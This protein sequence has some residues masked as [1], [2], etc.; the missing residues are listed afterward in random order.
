MTRRIKVEALARVEGEGALDVTVRDGRVTALHFRIFEPPRFFEALLRGRPYSDAPDITSRI[1]GIC[2]IA[3]Q[4]GA[5][6]AMED[7]FGVV[8]S[9][10]IEA[11]RRLVYCGEWI[12]S[13]VL[14]VAMLHAPDFLGLDDALLMA[15][16]HPEVVETALRLKKLGNRLLEVVGGRAVHP[17]NLK[18]GGFYA[19]PKRAE[20]LALRPELDWAAAAA[21]RLLRTVAAFDPPDLTRDYL[22]VAL[23]HDRDYAITGGRLASSEGLDAPIAA[24]PDLFD[25]H[26]EPNSTALHGRTRDGRAYMV[27]PLARWAING[28]RLLPD[29]RAEAAALGVAPVER[30]PFR[31]IVVRAAE[32]LQVVLEAQR[33]VDAYRPPDPPAVPVEPRAGVGVGATEAP[34]GLCWHRYRLADDGSIL[35]ARIVPPTAQNQPTIE[36]DLRQ[37]VERGLALD[38]DALKWRC[39]QAIRNYDPCISCATHFLRLKVH[40]EP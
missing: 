37:V 4:L 5:A 40:R 36:E 6:Q 17:V 31:S 27:G 29:V 38:D 26:Q 33:L 9:P 2:P 28:D 21:R 34:R 11:L 19:A 24:F 1:C 12:E 13:H 32:V 8:V 20:L 25:E 16:T 39:E 14:H 30:N 15:K 10:E 18:V 35:E 3:Y 7:A 22:F 23:R